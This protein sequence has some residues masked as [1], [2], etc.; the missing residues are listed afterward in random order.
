MLLD[1]FARI[2]THENGNPC[3]G[4]AA[5]K[6]RQHGQREDDISDSID[7]DKED[8]FNVVVQN[9]AADENGQTSLLRIFSNLIYGKHE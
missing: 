6:K 8:I 7:A 5:F 4:V 3:V 9:N 2:L 1:E